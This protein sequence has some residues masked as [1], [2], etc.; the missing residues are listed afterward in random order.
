[1]GIRTQWYIIQSY[2]ALEQGNPQQSI[3]ILQH[4]QKI[5]PND[6]DIYAYLGE[7]HFWNHQY[8]EALQAFTQRE[9]LLKNRPDPFLPYL[10]G[11]R[12]CILVEEGKLDLA[13]PLLQQSLD[14]GGQEPHFYYS[15]AKIQLAK[16]NAKEAKKI[17]EKI[18]QLDPC[19]YYRK[20]RELLKKNFGK[21]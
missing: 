20:I 2:D 3:S 11:Y 8:S 6:P 14:Q 16:G 7:A 5:A 12:G 4:A 9:E 18:E 1:M 17:L 15:L 19:F 21:I 13:L 10:Q